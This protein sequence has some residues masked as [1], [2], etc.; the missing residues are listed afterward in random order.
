[1]KQKLIFEEKIYTYQ[2][3]FVGHV[4]NIIYIQWLENGRVRLLEAI[5]LPAFDLAVS[6]GIVPVLTETSI[7]YKK[8]LFLNNTVTVEIWISKLNNASA[9]MNFRF[10]NEKTEVCAVA[11]QK[12][13]FINRKTMRPARL[14]EEYRRAFEKFM[15]LE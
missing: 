1:M 10:L 13:L 2:I 14:T 4:N 6:D 15:I 11:Q 12:G 9:I 5:G 7:K 8:P 3:D